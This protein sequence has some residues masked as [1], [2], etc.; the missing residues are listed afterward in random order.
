MFDYIYNLCLWKQ[1]NMRYWTVFN[2]LDIFLFFLFFNYVAC[3]H[4]KMF[5]HIGWFGAKKNVLNIF[6]L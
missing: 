5:E 6:V 3:G 1:Y 4:T 2:H